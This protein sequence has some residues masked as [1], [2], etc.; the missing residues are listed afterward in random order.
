MGLNS[1]LN[2]HHASIFP[3]INCKGVN[4][5]MGSPICFAY[6][7][8]V[9]TRLCFFGGSEVFISASELCFFGGSRVFFSASG[10]FVFS[11]SSWCFPWSG[12][13]SLEP[14]ASF[15]FTSDVLR[16]SP[17]NTAGRQLRR[18]S[19]NFRTSALS[20]GAKDCIWARIS[21]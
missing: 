17:R 7:P 16:P 18:C 6:F 21:S 8:G 4:D 13:A 2:I 9:A 3:C 10:L 11:P 15:Y 5:V 12:V 19:W 20:S 1:S 14:S